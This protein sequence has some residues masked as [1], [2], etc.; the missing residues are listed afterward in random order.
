VLDLQGHVLSWVKIG[1]ELLFT[2]QADEGNSLVVV[3][4]KSK[5]IK[6]EYGIPG[7]VTKV[8]AIKD[9]KIIYESQNK[10]KDIVLLK[11]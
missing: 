7:F 8:T 11:S 6:A 5:S 10:Q 1:T 2:L 4:L 3:D 9:G